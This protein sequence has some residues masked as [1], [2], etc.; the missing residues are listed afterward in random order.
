MYVPGEFCNVMDST[1]KLAN[2]EIRLCY[3]VATIDQ[4][5]EGIRR[6]AKAAKRLSA[7]QGTTEERAAVVA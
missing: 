2:N 5:K 3:G 4:I 1:G 6:L 7:L